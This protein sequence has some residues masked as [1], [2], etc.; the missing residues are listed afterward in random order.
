MVAI[1]HPGHATDH[2]PVLA[3]MVVH[4]Q[5]EAGAGLDL[6]ALDLEARAFFEHGVGA[7]GA[8]HG[9]VELVRFVALALSGW[10]RGA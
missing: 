10:R 4:L 7:P 9:A 1:D 2:D 3:A 5:A 8:V 6:D